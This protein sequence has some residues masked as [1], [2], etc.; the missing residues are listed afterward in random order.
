MALFLFV[1]YKDA[2][3]AILKKAEIQRKLLCEKA[4]ERKRGHRYIISVLL[5]FVKTIAWEIPNT[6]KSMRLGEGQKGRVTQ[7]IINICFQASIKRSEVLPLVRK[8]IFCF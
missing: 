4:S 8:Q 5:Q 3:A 7:Q 1:C 6:L 2:A